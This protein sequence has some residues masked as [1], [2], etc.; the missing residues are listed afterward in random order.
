MVNLPEKK[1]N[2]GIKGLYIMAFTPE[3]L[4]PEKLKYV[5]HVADG[6]VRAKDPIFRR[7]MEEQMAPQTRIEIASLRHVPLMHTP[8]TMQTA[9]QGW[10]K[11]RYGVSYEPVVG[12]NFFP[13]GMKDP[14]GKETYILFYFDMEE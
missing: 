3:E 7:L 8:Q 13:H 6:M 11:A 5:V 4:G 1:N 2:P 10:L 12:K 14:Q 9:M